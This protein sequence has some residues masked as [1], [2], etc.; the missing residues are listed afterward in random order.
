MSVEEIIRKDCGM[1][2]LDGKCPVCG[3]ELPVVPGYC[4]H[5]GQKVVKDKEQ[6]LRRWDQRYNRPRVLIDMDDC[7][8]C[9]TDHLL[10]VYNQRT[11]ADLK[12]SDIRE[13]NLQKYIGDYGMSIFREEGFFENIPEKNGSVSVLK[14]LIM[15]RDYDVYVITACGSN[16]ELE[17]KYHW[18]E[19]YLPE[20]NRN[21]IIR[22][23]EKE[24]IHG[25]VLID[26]NPDNLK[27]C[28]PFM[29]TVVYDMPTNQDVTDMIRI[30][31][32]KD[33]V[34]LLREWFY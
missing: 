2:E 3:N 6:R 17:E 22:C 14:D 9:F 24:L 21:R 31:S 18:F 29:K 28:R 7:I 19:K 27:K 33:V 11:G 15:S 16:Q 25:D 26:D 13:W 30:H 34:P 1:L 8:N 4:C 23:K 5:C 12:T 10:K 32:L 20:F